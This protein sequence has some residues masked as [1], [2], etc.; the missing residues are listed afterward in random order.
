MHYGL[1][2]LSPVNAI[3]DDW[4]DFYRNY[5]SSGLSISQDPNHTKRPNQGAGVKLQTENRI[6]VDVAYLSQT[7]CESH[8]L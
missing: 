5:Y 3:I 7:S 4:V 2:L 8:C 1:A 6:T